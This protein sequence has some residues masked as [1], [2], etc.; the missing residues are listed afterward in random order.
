MKKD[1]SQNVKFMDSMIAKMKELSIDV[2]VII[3][4]EGA[5]PIPLTCFGVDTI[6]SSGYAFTSGGEK[7]AMASVIDAQDVEESEMYD[8]V[9]H[10]QDF[11][12]D[13]AALVRQ[14]PHKVI[15]F[16]YSEE[17]PLCDGLTMGKYMQF[18]NALGDKDF[19]AVSSDTF[20]PA[21]MEMAK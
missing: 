13:F 6:G 10:Y 9:V 15:A 16:D 7:L 18:V 2:Y 17:V 12:T 3:T 8:K 4:G 5:D 19:K 1:Y 11:Y 21:V 14:L 20:I